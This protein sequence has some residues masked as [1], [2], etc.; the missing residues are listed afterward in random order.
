MKNDAM[1]TVSELAQTWSDK[2]I[3]DFC[4]YLEKLIAE[5]EM[6]NSSDCRGSRVVPLAKPDGQGDRAYAQVAHRA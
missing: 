6:H 2:Q 4:E 5:D 1:D 3:L